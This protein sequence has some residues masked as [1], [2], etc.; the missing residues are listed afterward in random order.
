[1]VFV[2]EAHQFYLILQAFHYTATLLASGMDT[3]THMHT[4]THTYHPFLRQNQFKK[5]G[6]CQPQS[7]I[8]LTKIQ[9]ATFKNKNE[10]INLST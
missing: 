7:Y 6:A 8:H 2:Y 4:N 3:Y 10:A 1:M 9:E 5:L